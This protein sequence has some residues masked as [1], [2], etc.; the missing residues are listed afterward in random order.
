MFLLLDHHD[1]AILFQLNRSYKTIPFLKE[2]IR[3]E[4]IFSN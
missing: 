2:H 1:H 3:N 4:K